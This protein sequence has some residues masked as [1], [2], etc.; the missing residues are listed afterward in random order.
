MQKALSSFPLPT[1]SKTT[2][3]RPFLKTSS[4]RW[5]D[6]FQKGYARV[7]SPIPFH[8]RI[9][10]TLP[11]DLMSLHELL[12]CSCS[13]IRFRF[14]FI[15]MLQLG[16]HIAFYSVKSHPLE[17][18]S[19]LRFCDFVLYPPSRSS[20]AAFSLHCLSLLRLSPKPG[21]PECPS[22]VLF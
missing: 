22:S 11:S 15:L 6:F 1:N 2:L 8:F 16:L 12:L 21:V 9:Q 18:L 4:C 3:T 5:S 10:C 7:G 20:G 17:T 13:K 14:L 19:S